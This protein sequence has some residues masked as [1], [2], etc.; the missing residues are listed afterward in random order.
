MQIKVKRRKSQVELPKLEV[1]T[2]PKEMLSRKPRAKRQTRLG[3][4][5][6]MVSQRIREPRKMRRTL[7]PS[8]VSPPKAGMKRP[9]KQNAMQSG[10]MI[11]RNVLLSFNAIKTPLSLNNEKI[12]SF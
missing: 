7:K 12:L 1:K 8:L 3:Q 4:S 10:M 11:Q 6:P 9:T 5:M 2:L